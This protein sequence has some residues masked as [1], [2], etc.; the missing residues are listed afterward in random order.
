MSSKLAPTALPTP[1]K[2]YNIGYM[3]RLTKQIALEFTKQKAVTPVT[4][5]SDLSSESGYPISGLTIINVPTSPTG[6]P[7]GSVWSDGGTLKIVS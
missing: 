1:P 6:L 4:C 2:E 3:D 7:S 5:G